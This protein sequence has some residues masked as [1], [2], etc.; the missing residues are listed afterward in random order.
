MTGWDELVASALLGTDRRTP[1]FRVLPSSVR[2]RLADRIPA[3]DAERSTDPAAE[4]D[5]QRDVAVALLDAAALMTAYR[6]AGRPAVRELAPVAAAPVDHRPLPREAAIRRLAMILDGSHASVLPE[7]LRAVHDRGYRVPPEHLPALADLARTRPQLRPDVAAVAG[8]RASWLAG[9]NPEWRVLAD[10]VTADDG[11]GAWLH[12]SPAQRKD[13]LAATRR[14]DPDAAREALAGTWSAEPAPVRAELLGLL[15]ANLSAADEEFCEAALDDRAREVRLV[16]AR[17]LAGSPGSR[18][19]DRMAARVRACLTVRRR[20]GRRRGVLVVTLPTE[21]DAAMQRDGIDPR[22]R[23]VVG[24]RA[25]WL[26]EIVAAAPLA[27]LAGLAGS[28]AE[29][30][31]L[32]VDGCDAGLLHAAVA[33]A[34]VR[35]RSAEWARALLA[36]NPEAGHRVT[37]LVAILPP[38]EWAGVVASLRGTVD[39]ADVVGSL[40]VPWPADL[41]RAMLDLLAT[42]SPD[43]GWARLASITGRAVPAGALDHPLVGRPAGEEDTWRRRL[44]ETLVF[45]REMYK[46]LS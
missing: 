18:Y 20:R 17:L 44:I 39:L 8:P 37:E 3:S 24:E 21:C 29:F 40:P 22:P 45:R 6:R 32:E 2:D 15:A 1:D 25:W 41:A 26:R 46:E 33:E 35:E 16:A 12:G 10:Q 34:I 27:A 7:W 38:R 13:W 42:A 23:Q 9:M 11:D 43:Q 14:R 19:A 28:P 5:G 4:G 36:T 30:L 31:R